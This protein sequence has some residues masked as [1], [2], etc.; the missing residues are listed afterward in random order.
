MSDYATWYEFRQD[1]QKRSGRT[2]L[3][4]VWLDVKPVSP[5]PWNESQLRSALLRLSRS[6]KPKQ[7]QRT[8]IGT[9]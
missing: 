9:N 6:R 1:L 2:L 3:N 8:R 5:L 4:A 7:D